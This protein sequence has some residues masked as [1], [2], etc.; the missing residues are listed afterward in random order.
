VLTCEGVNGSTKYS[1]GGMAPLIRNSGLSI[2]A[3]PDELTIEPGEPSKLKNGT[4]SLEIGA[5]LKFEG[6]AAQELI[7]VKNP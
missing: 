6:Y 5:S 2:G 7:E 1:E 4:E 3:F